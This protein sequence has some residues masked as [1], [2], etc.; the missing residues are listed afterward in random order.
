MVTGKTWAWLAAGVAVIGAG[1]FAQ[2]GLMGGEADDAR[3]MV[4]LP[5]T[6][7]V[8]AKSTALV[9]AGSP[10]EPDGDRRRLY[11]CL[12]SL[13]GGNRCRQR[14]RQRLYHRRQCNRS[15]LSVRP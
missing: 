4:Q 2:G 6:A 11:L 9:S 1:A 12:D 15:G 7:A 13:A 8:A 3:P 5:P 10:G 14:G